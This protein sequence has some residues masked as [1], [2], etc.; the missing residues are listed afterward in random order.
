MPKEEQIT[1][2]NGHIP[3]SGGSTNGLRRRAWDEPS[4]TITTTP[5]QKLSCQ[6]HPGAKTWE[7]GEVVYYD[8]TPQQEENGFTAVD[9]F[10][11]GGLMATG[12]QRAGWHIVWANDFE[13]TAVQA[14]QYNIG[15]HITL[16]D[17][18]KIPLESI[19]FADA[20][21][22]GPPCQ[23]FSV[24]GEGRGE[25]GDRGKLVYTYR[26]IIAA[27]QPKAFLF[28]NVKG[29]LTKKH[30]PTF[31]KLL[32]LFEEAGYAVTWKLIN[33]WD[34]GVAQK[35]E[36]VF[37]VGIRKDLGFM[38]QFPE[39]REGDY[40]TQLLRD[41]IGD[42]PEPMEGPGSVQIGD[43]PNHAPDTKNPPYIQ[44]VIDGKTTTNYGNGIPV[45]DGSLPAKTLISQYRGKCPN[46][47]VGMDKV[48][49]T[50]PDGT[51][52]WSVPEELTMAAN[53]VATTAEI[54]ENH[55]GALFDNVNPNWTYEQT[56]RQADFD[57]AGPT[58]SA[59]SR[60]EMIHP[61]DKPKPRRFTVR[62]CLRIQSVPDSYVLPSALSLSAQ[63]KI[64][65]NGVASYVAYQLALALADQ[66]NGAN[67]AVKLRRTRLLRTRYPKASQA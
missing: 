15:D 29:L 12:V 45:N 58:V 11:G 53:E 17:I 35:R 13:K 33:A 44:N 66:L 59:H 38:F 54:P 46:E 42:L 41:A 52:S 57:K 2:W 18:K 4:G 21:I 67:P 32:A 26:D 27:K 14:Y 55:M 25:D 61:I 56:M 50:Q 47:V 20:I 5:L 9:L 10:A 23:D 40:R 16:G 7:G 28:E 51:E 62:E 39:P 19:P 60:C 8:K 31:D 1:Y 63:Y 30:R 6:M 43:T 24:A 48:R 49:I 22:G 34:Y 3:Q 37:I 36:R 64:V 65:G